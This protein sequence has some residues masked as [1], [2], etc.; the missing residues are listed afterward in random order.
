MA[1][2][3]D[4]ICFLPVLATCSN[5][6]YLTSFPTYYQLFSLRDLAY[7]EQFYWFMAGK[8]TAVFQSV[9]KQILATFQ[10]M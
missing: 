10:G 7:L 9:C 3:L 8:I 6:V 2:F 4:R 1:I 5:H